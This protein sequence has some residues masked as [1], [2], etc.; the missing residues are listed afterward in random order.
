MMP[1]RQSIGGIGVTGEKIRGIGSLF[2]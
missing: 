2:S 1:A